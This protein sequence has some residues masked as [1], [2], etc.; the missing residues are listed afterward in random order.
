MHLSKHHG[1][2]NDFLVALESLNGPLSGDPAV[3][4][5]LCDRHT[6]VGA[7][8]L[9]WGAASD[10]ADVV[11]RLH[12][13]DGTDAEIS[14]NGLRCLV[15]AHLRS[16]GRS[17]GTVSVATPGGVRRAVATATSDPTTLSVSAEM[18]EVKQ[19]PELPAV[20][21]ELGFD[22]AATGSVGNPHVVLLGPGSLAPDLASIDL[23]KVGRRIEDAVPGGANVHIIELDGPDTLVMRPWERGVGITEACGSGATVAAWVARDWGLV[24]DSVTVRM[25]GGATVV[26]L[27]GA[28]ASLVGP[29]SYVADVE[30]P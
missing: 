15:Q 14:G 16:V 27:N 23:T 9:I 24:G 25:P 20:V 30:T 17:E 3:A 29:A 22:Q 19:G 6:G 18:G 5:A 21:G 1:L 4:R 8:G 10:E 2:G 28:G 7:D 11:F 26:E 13:A 12:N